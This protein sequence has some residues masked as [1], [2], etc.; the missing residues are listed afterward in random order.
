M[1]SIV[2]AESDERRHRNH[3]CKGFALSL[4]LILSLIIF[5]FGKSKHLYEQQLTLTQVTSSL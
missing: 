4:L 5:C 3:R 2:D 1:A